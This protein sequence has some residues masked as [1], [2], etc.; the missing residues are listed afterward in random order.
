MTLGWSCAP[1]A[2]CRRPSFR[3]LSAVLAAQQQS[4]SALTPLGKSHCRASGAGKNP[5]ANLTCVN[6]PGPTFHYGAEV[7]DF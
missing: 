3:T 7:W 6:S 2:R 4:N 1:L 5:C